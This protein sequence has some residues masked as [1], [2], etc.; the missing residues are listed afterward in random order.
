MTT[1]SEIGDYD[2]TIA[3]PD[4][5]AAIENYYGVSIKEADP[6]LLQLVVQQSRKAGNEA[7]KARNHKG[8]FRVLIVC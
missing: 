4:Q 5:I 8:V 2:P 1:T 3:H 7:Y 6:N